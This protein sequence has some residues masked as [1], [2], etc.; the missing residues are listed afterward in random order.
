MAAAPFKVKAIYEYTSSHEDDLPFDVGQVM[1]VIEDDDPDWYTGEYVDASGEKREG[2]FPRNFVEKF[3]PVA[4]PRPTRSKKKEAEPPVPPTPAQEP[5]PEPEPEQEQEQEP[6]PEAEPVPQEPEEVEEETP[7]ASPPPPAAAE[8]RSPKAPVA[9]VSKPVEPAPAAEPAVQ[10][11]AKAPAPARSGPPPVSGKPSS[12]AFKDRIAAFNKPAA[13]PVAPFKPGG[14]GSG[15]SSGFIKKPFVAAP[16]SRNAYVPPPREAAPTAKVYRREEDPEIKEKEA[17]NTENAAKAGLVPTQEGQDEDQPKPM[18]LKERMAL[19][20]KQ[21]AEAASRHADAAAKKKKPERPPKKR[22]ESQEP[23]ERGSI[24]IPETA[25]PPLE[26]RNTESTDDAQPPPPPRQSLPSRRKS[27]RGPPED[28]NEADMSG[29]GDTT[30]GPE[31]LTEREDSDA[32]T[33]GI[34]RAPTGASVASHDKARIPEEGEE[35][36]AEEEEDD[37]EDDEDPEVRR[38]EE[39]RA[40]MAKMSAGMGGLGMMGMN[41]FAAPLGS[42][43][44]AK[45]K[46]PPPV[47]RRASEQAEDANPT[48]RMA[49]P[50]VPTMMALPGMGKKSEEKEAEAEEQESPVEEDIT[51]VTSATSRAVPEPPTQSPGGPPPVPSGRPAP[52]PVPAESRPPPPPPPAGVTSPSVGSESDDEL[53]ESQLQSVETPRGEAP[54]TSRAPPPI[55]VAS[56]TMAPASPR[57]AGRRTSYMGA[58]TSPTSPDQPSKRNSRPPPPI[59][60]SAPLPPAQN[61]APPPPPPGTAPSRTSTS[62]ERVVSPMKP[63]HLDNGEEEEITEYDGDYDTDIGSSVPHKDALKSHARDSSFDES[64][65]SP[66]S[67]AAPPSL[68]PPIPSAAAPRAV[69]PPIPSQPPPPPA[70]PSADMP[71]AAPPPPPPPK[72]ETYAQDDDEYDP[73]NYTASRPA[74]PTTLSYSISRHEEEAASPDNAPSYQSPPPPTTRAPPPAPP[75]NR[76]PRQ[77]LDV[78]RPT[79]GRRSMDV[80]RPSISMESGFVANDLDLAPHTNWW[81]TPNGVPPTLQGRR[82]VF[83]ESEESTTSAPGGRTVVTKEVYVL[84]QDY[85]QT[86]I[87]VRYDP[88]NPSDTQLDQRHEPPPRTLRQDQLEQAYERFG[89]QISNTIPSKKDSVVGDGSPHSLVYELLRPFKDALLP[90]GTRT[91]GALVYANIANASTTMNDEIRP[92]DIISIRN[93]K[94]SGKHGAMH[95]KYSMEVGKPDHVAIVAEWDGTKKK[96][97]AW[98]QGRESKKVKQ[99]SFKLEDLRSGE[100]KIWRIMPR[101]WVG[102]DSSN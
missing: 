35:E 54:P 97:R 58:E 64:V 46:K 11:P 51:P 63:G 28:G 75:S 4:P 24:D 12:S 67:D 19:L 90:V 17:E 32:Q 91:Y 5:H 73:Y 84:F 8:P 20:Q 95:A 85:S 99:E 96:V 10:P 61:R 22:T 60:G 26:R 3:E 78:S 52:P 68:P 47:E 55:P 76:A 34:S 44:A 87:T 37:E 82:D 39:L 72:T 23:Q 53:S 36:E 38:K 13:P 65:R 16:P 25:S 2:I 45:K 77:S 57:P 86:I 14:L 49:P 31:E 62:D 88:Q 81:S 101:S 42:S 80:N 18:S 100:V 27:S 94:F 6:E 59:P 15:G 50:P 74:A 89:L 71:R 66:V 56:P 98:E 29:A 41:P 7:I 70:R 1:T 79:G 102:W 92:G 48:P 83:F 93:A 9:P 30:E 21:Q 33:K 40:R 43:G 69:P